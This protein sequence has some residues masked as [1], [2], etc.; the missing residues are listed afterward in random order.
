MVSAMP[1]DAA[2]GMSYL[3]Q[4]LKLDPSY[5][6]AHAY[7]AWVLEI[8]FVRAALARP[9]QQ[10]ACATPGRRW[11]MEPMMRRRSLSHC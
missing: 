3:E 6:A 7:M 4:A 11:R 1:E 8:R 2:I 5:A 9:M 10:P